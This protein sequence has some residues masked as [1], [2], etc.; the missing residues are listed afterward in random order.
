MGLDS[1]P[2]TTL[3]VAASTTGAI[4]KSSGNRKKSTLRIGGILPPK[5]VHSRPSY[6][7]REHKR[8]SPCCGFG[9][10]FATSTIQPKQQ[11]KLL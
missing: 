6:G 1:K 7:G 4:V 9:I 3:N 11:E 2:Q 5:L 8:Y 10:V